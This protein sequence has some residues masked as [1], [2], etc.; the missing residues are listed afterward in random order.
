MP[1]EIVDNRAAITEPQ[2]TFGPTGRPNVQ[3]IQFLTGRTGT[4]DEASGFTKMTFL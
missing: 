3:E 1:Q 4:I 2:K